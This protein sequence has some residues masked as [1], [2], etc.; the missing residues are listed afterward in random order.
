MRSQP[1]FPSIGGNC[2]CEIR[3]LTGS[4]TIASNDRA[5]PADELQACQCV[6][7]DTVTLNGQTVDGWCYLDAT[8]APAIGNQS[9]GANCSEQEKRMIRFSDS[10][11]ISGN[12]VFITCQN[13]TPTW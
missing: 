8:G 7:D 12:P 6:P 13:D 4:A 9:I 11:M 10:K 3:Q 5:A 2:L 1:A